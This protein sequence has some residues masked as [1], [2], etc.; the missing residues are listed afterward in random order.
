VAIWLWGQ[1]LEKAHHKYCTKSGR[2]CLDKWPNTL[3]ILDQREIAVESTNRCRER[4]GIA[5][6]LVV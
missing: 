6:G 5:T 4:N 1:R 2:Q 3:A